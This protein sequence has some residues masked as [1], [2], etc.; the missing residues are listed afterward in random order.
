MYTDV[1]E[2]GSEVWFGEIPAG[3]DG[4]PMPRSRHGLADATLR[5]M[6]A[7][8]V[9]ESIG[10]SER[11]VEFDEETQKKV[12][13]GRRGAKGRGEVT[14]GG[15]AVNRPTSNPAREHAW[16]SPA[17]VSQAEQAIPDSGAGATLLR[18]PLGKIWGSK[19]LEKMYFR[20]GNDEIVE[21]V[22]GEP[23]DTVMMDEDGIWRVKRTAPG[24]VVGAAPYTLLS[25][26][27]SQPYGL[28]AA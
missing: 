13:G 6:R 28:G 9:C 3:P 14:S 2:L 15:A 7:A 23:V 5:G 19:K 10:R 1:D 8:S 16:P 27:A 18:G 4:E 21:G 25:I 11:V 26:P 20:V 12:E 22:G 17:W 24:Y